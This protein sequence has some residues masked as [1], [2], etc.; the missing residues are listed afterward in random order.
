MESLSFYYA[1]QRVGFFLIDTFG[2]MEN[3]LDT[4]HAYSVT[5]SVPM[6]CSDLR[7]AMQEKKKSI[8]SVG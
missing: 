6:A 2:Y 1:E 4:P 7:G 8:F 5:G 3:I